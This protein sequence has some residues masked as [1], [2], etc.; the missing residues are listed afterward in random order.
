MIS[1]NPLRYPGGK[2]YLT[3]YV[4]ALIECS[5][6]TGCTLCEPYAGSAAVS[7]DMLA[8]GLVDRVVLIEKDPLLYSF[9]R[10][11]AE[12][13]DEL[14]KRIGQLDV[15]LDTWN[16]LL[17]FRSAQ[18]PLEHPLLD[19]AVACVFYNRTNFSG[20]LAAN[21]LGGK[22][23]TSAYSIDCRFNKTTVIGHIERIAQYHE[24]MRVKWADA[25]SFMRASLNELNRDRC[26]VYADPPYYEKGKDL[27]RYH[28][29]DQQHEELARLLKK[30]RFSWL[31]SYDDHPFIEELYF[32]G[33]SSLKSQRLHLDYIAQKRKQG[34]ELLISNLDIPPVKE[35]M[36]RTAG[37]V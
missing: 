31:L 13:P 29:S 23:Q 5:N 4:A 20:I 19:M 22:S 1:T 24:H 3:D 25:V 34:R 14:C 17:S 37:I 36:G 2:H 35:A 10:A 16:R 12:C 6:L 27:Y 11:V 15:S 21:P 30:A 26:L 33:T 7:L 28:Y 18:T 32:G 8:R 9:W